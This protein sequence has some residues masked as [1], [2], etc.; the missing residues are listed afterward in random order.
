MAATLATTFTE[1][2]ARELTEELKSDYGAIRS[3]IGAA[4]RGRIWTALG[5]DS[6][7]DYLDAEFVD[8]TLRPPKELEEQVVSELRGGHE[9]TRYR[10]GN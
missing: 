2:T 6:W 4:W 8:L 9:H 5:Y 3:K 10:C 1:A 7:Q